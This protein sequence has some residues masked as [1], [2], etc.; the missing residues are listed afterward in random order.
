VRWGGGGVT[1]SRESVR[2]VVGIP[3]D[4][5]GEGLMEVGLIL[6][7]CVIVWLLNGV[8]GMKTE[9]R[10]SAMKRDSDAAGISERPV[11]KAAN[12]ETGCVSVII[13]AAFVG[14]GIAIATTW[15]ETLMQ[16]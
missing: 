13:W 3:I 16:R 6:I 5:V 8:Q 9:Q 15:M 12:A 4:R 14:G 11:I 1:Q 2:L 7:G 10:I